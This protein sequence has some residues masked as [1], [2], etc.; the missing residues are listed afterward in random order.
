MPW[1]VWRLDDRSGGGMLLV[2]W[3]RPELTAAA[4]VRHLVVRWT[5]VLARVHPLGIV[6]VSGV[7]AV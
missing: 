6:L 1:S 2:V 7:N 3:V 4:L 5:S